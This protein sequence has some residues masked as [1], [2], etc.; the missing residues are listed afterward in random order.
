MK[1]GRLLGAALALA[2]LIGGMHAFAQSVQSPMVPVPSVGAISG[3]GTSGDLACVN[4]NVVVDCIN[5]SAAALAPG[6]VGAPNGL[7]GL[8]Q[9]GGVTWVNSIVGGVDAAGAVTVYSISNNGG[10]AGAFAA[11]TS[12]SPFSTPHNM[13]TDLCVMV[14]DNQTVAHNSWCQYIVGEFTASAVATSEHMNVENSLINLGAVAIED[15]FTPNP[16]STTENLRLDSGNGPASN[17]VSAAL[18]ILANG[19]KYAAG[20]IIGN[21][22]LDSALNTNPPWIEIPAGA[23]GPS[24]EWFSAAA[25]PNWSLYSTDTGSV[26]KG[27]VLAP[28]GIEYTVSGSPVYDYGTTSAGKHTFV[29]Q[30]LTG[31]SFVLSA[32]TGTYQ[33]RNSLTIISS[34]ATANVRLGTSDAASPVAQ[35][36]DVQGVFAG[37]GNTAG[38]NFTIAGS[39]SNGSGGGDVI[40]QTTLSSAGSGTQNA[41]A[42][43][44]TLKGGTQA[45]SLSGDLQ[46][47][48]TLLISHTA[49][50]ISSGCGGGSPSISANNGASNFR[51]TIGTA[52]GSTCVINMPTANAGW[53]CLANDLSTH[54]TANSTV[55]QTATG[56]SQITLTGFSDI[57]GAATWVSGDV[58]AVHCMAL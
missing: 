6:G 49:P 50:T 56:A 9:P 57:T 8:A 25:T 35:L 37:N 41:L 34:Q 55:M 3:A 28:A 38:A 45:A 14:H 39:K 22:A 2:L 52:S 20:I 54:T 26:L 29:G 40:F 44:L 31:A 53:N 36:L 46:I 51:V 5:V 13:I 16:N 48:G 33:L 1:F 11:R 42:T 30:V 43:A 21:G 27:I 47:A 32:N 58:I 19:G 4:D 24:M 7:F 23:N 15:P 12:D 17:D 10:Y 18:T